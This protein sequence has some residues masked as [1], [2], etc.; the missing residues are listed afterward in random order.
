MIE[1]T[2]ACNFFRQTKLMTQIFFRAHRLH[3][4]QYHPKTWAIASAIFLQNYWPK[5]S[6]A[7]GGFREFSQTCLGR[8]CPVRNRRSNGV[9]L[10]AAP[11]KPSKVP[12][13]SG[14]ILGSAHAHH[15]AT[16]SALVS[17][18]RMKPPQ[19]S[20]ALPKK[21]R[22]RGLCVLR[23]A[24]SSGHSWQELLQWVSPSLSLQE[25]QVHLRFLIFKNLIFLGLVKHFFTNNSARLIHALY[26][27]AA[28]FFHSKRYSNPVI[29]REKK[30]ITRH[31]LR[32]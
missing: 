5:R 8:T 11:R 27:L 1:L 4:G 6:R 12:Q 26:K 31:G 19:R 15:A 3:L 16:V 24:P 10:L 20:H 7:F 18:K 2:A 22:V 13:L 28:D 17:V 25:M 30:R 9:K 14:C 29:L 23:K 21:K 32:F